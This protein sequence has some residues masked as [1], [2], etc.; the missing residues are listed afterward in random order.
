MPQIQWK[1]PENYGEDKFVIMFSGLHI[2][3][4]ALK[5]LGDWLKGSGWVQANVTTPGIADSFLQACSNHKS[6]SSYSYRI[7]YFKESRL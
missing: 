1:W 7:I 5:T 6:P 2:E 4:A 3:M